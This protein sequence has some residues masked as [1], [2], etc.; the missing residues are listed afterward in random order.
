MAV[1]LDRVI[2]E[3]AHHL[4][5]HPLGGAYHNRPALCRNRDR[6]PLRRQPKS[7][8]HLTAELIEV[9]LRLGQGA[10]RLLQPGEL[11]DVPHQVLQPLRLVVD[12]RGKARDVL[13]AGNPLAHQLGIAGDG[14]QRGL[15]LV[16]DV[17]GE[18][19]AHA[20]L[21]P[22]LL[23]EQLHLAADLAVLLVDARDERAQL[24]VDRPLVRPLQ[25]DRVYRAHQRAGRAPGEDERQH[26]RQHRHQQ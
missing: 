5:Q 12:P 26:E 8:G 13:R 10:V 11:D 14:G 20:V 17:G 4:G 23:G 9:D 16:G 7:L 18:L 19:L 2:T 1:I 24:G 25:V 21:P 6:L 22:V 3:V 15:E